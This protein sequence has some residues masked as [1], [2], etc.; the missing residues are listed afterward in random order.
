MTPPAPLPSAYS[1][2]HPMAPSQVP[3]TGY[4]HGLLWKRRPWRARVAARRVAR[5]NASATGHGKKTVMLISFTALLAA[6]IGERVPIHGRAG[7]GMTALGTA[8]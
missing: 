1:P 2:R 5:A 7:K 8:A 3:T 6:Q 4:P